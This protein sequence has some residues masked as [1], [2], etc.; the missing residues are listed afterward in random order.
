MLVWLFVGF[1]YDGLRG[2]S[3]VGCGVRFFCCR[4]GVCGFIEVEWF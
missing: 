3:I 4:F 2:S 1:G